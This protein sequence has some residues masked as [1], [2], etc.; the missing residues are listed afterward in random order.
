[1]APQHGRERER[2]SDSIPLFFMCK[3]GER[4]EVAAAVML[5]LY[6]SRNTS[7]EKR[8][9]RRRK[10]SLLCRIVFPGEASFYCT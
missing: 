1:M 4:E 10:P 7:L 9:R 5:L 8:R 3:S 2:P 6:L